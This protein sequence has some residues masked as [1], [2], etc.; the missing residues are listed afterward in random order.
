MACQ[1]AMGWDS[2]VEEEEGEE[3]LWARRHAAESHRRTVQEEGVEVAWG[4]RW[5]EEWWGGGRWSC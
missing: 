1:W 3:D 5:R 2:E 4:R